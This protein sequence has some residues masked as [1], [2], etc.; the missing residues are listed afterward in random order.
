[1]KIDQ[2]EWVSKGEIENKIM[3]SV[4]DFKMSLAT[5]DTVTESLGTKS[6]VTEIPMTESQVIKFRAQCYKT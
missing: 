3:L 5:Q 1:M 6:Q 4:V 2:D